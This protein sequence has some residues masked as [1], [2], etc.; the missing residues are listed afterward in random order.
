MIQ[1][2]GYQGAQ[3]ATRATV[4][5]DSPAGFPYALKESA[6]VAAGYGGSLKAGIHKLVINQ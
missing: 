3:E 6:V 5:H 2:V 1:M 4:R